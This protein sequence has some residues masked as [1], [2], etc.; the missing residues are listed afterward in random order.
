MPTRPEIVEKGQK[1]RRVE[2]TT[3]INGTISKVKWRSEN[4]WIEP[5][6]G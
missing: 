3:K 1:S 4:L 6:P 2:A 5:K